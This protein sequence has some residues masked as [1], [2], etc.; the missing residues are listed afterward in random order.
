M[1]IDKKSHMNHLDDEEV[2]LV[3]N[4]YHQE[5]DQ[6]KKAESDRQFARDQLKNKE[7]I[8]KETQE[9]KNESIFVNPSPN[10]DAPHEQ[11][12]ENKVSETDFTTPKTHIQ[13]QHIDSLNI[14]RK[15]ITPEE[16][17]NKLPRPSNRPHQTSSFNEDKHQP[18]DR[19]YPQGNQRF[20]RTNPS[21]SS[22]KRE[23]PPRN[24]FEQSKK[25]RY[26]Q[27][28]SIHR[29]HSQQH[30]HHL[31]PDRSTQ[32][33]KQKRYERIDRTK[34]FDRHPR[35]EQQEKKGFHDR[36]QRPE[37]PSGTYD[38]NKRMFDH[39]T[40]PQDQRPKDDR[41]RKIL[42]DRN[43]QRS[44]FPKAGIVKPE[45]KPIVDEKVFGKIKQTADEFGDR[46]KHLQAKLKNTKR[47][48]KGEI[49]PEVDEAVLVKNI[50]T[51]MSGSKRKKRTRREE[52]NNPR[53][54]ERTNISISEFTSVSEL[55]KILDVQPGEIIKKF[56]DMGK[57]V[58]INH[59]LDRESLEIICS[60]YDLAINFHDEF[61]VDLLQN[62]IDLLHHLEIQPK[63][64]VVTI[65][66]HVD[67]GKTS[68][69]DRIR[70]TKVVISE[71][72]GITQHIGAYQAIHKKHKIT[73]IDTPGHEAFTSMR[74]RG[75][76]ITDVAVIVVAANDGVKPQTIEAIDHA[77]A[78]GVSMVIAINKMDL[79]EANLDKTIASLLEQNVFL[80]GYGGQIPW[81]RCS[82]LRGTGI[83]DL[84][85]IILLSAEMKDLKARFNGPGKGVV[86]ETEKNSQM[87]VKA[88]ILL[89]EGVLTKGDIIV[90]GSS[91][92]HV[93]K[94]INENSKELTSI[95]P[96][97]IAVI[98]GLN[99]VPK[100]GDLLNV[101]DNEKIAK[102]IGVERQIIRH[103]REKLV[104]KTT[105]DN[106]FIKIKQNEMSELKLI[107]KG[108]VD[109]SVEALC[110]AAQKL[111]TDEVKISILRKS[112][113]GIIEADVNLASASNAIIIGFNVRTNNK[114]KKLAE[115]SGVE[116]KFYDI[117]FEAI[118]DIK[119]AMLGLL[120]PEL[121]EKILGQA[122]VK[123]IFKI[124]KVGTIAGCS[125]E[126]GII[127]SKSRIRLF[128]E[129]KL[130]YTGDLQELRHYNNAV[131]EVQAG[132][133]CGITIKNYNDLREGDTLE[134]FI[135][136]ELARESL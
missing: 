41:Q 101:V 117:I 35:P 98:F 122:L 107:V 105:L 19:Q 54:E 73:F 51:T 127:T 36:P 78:A 27:T 106:I 82:A 48:R 42:P 131:K 95:Y 13:E 133:D 2:E 26:P 119:K 60:E 61:G 59:R 90:V 45:V 44:T 38:R 135:M 103:E 62:K 20:T 97:D 46:S 5:M 91:Y 4:K 121:R 88:T 69:L 30:E 10:Y 79:P 130:I 22:G 84:L 94:M 25:G 58:A 12:T 18:R 132:S 49:L 64:P 123:Q 65:M 40:G 72:G 74:A 57:M 134:C 70:N 113:G 124:K 75:A 11:E 37:R 31:Y 8:H 115:E 80:E 136:E 14:P 50:K 28:D 71:S 111:S 9:Q 116:V 55:A 89:Q 17:E 110:D 39:R 21:D 34:P 76:C 118:N 6:H 92:G 102:Q 24:P 96:S 112:V 23:Y 68:I 43:Q 126:K 81:V 114:A 1:S 100:A 67:H 29:P 63:P 32:Q 16:R 109:G 129:E 99:H 77:R 128:R 125:V 120:S 47:S 85:E 87:G 52:R 104:S 93:R 33:D 83:D 86:I 66:G 53:F 15:I 3:R 56:M 7:R 108:D